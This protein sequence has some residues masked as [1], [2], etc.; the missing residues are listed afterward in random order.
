MLTSSHNF[1]LVSFG[2]DVVPAA[3]YAQVEKVYIESMGLTART[4]TNEIVYWRDRYNGLFEKS[5]D[6]LYV[7]GLLKEREVIGF[8]LVFYFKSQNLL[9]VDHI[10]ITEPERHF[11]AFFYF[12]ELIAQHIADEGLQ[13]DY[14][15]V[16]IVTSKEGDPHPVEPHLLIELLKQREFKVV[17]MPYYT[18][19]IKEDDYQHKIDTILMIMRHD[20]GDRISA[21]RMLALLECLLFDLYLRWY[22]PH[23]KDLRGFRR[24]LNSLFAM[25]REELSTEEY[26]TLNGS[27]HP[28]TTLPIIAKPSGL[29]HPPSTVLT[30]VLLLVVL[31]PVSA[32]L[33]ALS[34]W[35][36]ASTL[37]C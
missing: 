33:L 13:V 17:K 24:Q 1:G 8:A 23:S 16:E 2:Q 11:G 29:A 14:V 25:Y 15:L 10:T 19:S 28:N 30:P 21:G 3:T 12:K 26:G 34:Y 7:Y 18:P 32:C 4:N 22:T 6:R 27:A 5:G 36:G 9:V 37:T 20:R 31:L 35:L